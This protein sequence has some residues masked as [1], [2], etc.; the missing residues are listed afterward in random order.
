MKVTTAATVRGKAEEMHMDASG[1]W[2]SADSVTIKSEQQ[3]A[4]QT[5]FF[6]S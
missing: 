5:G 1:K 3:R 2:L 6:K 4:M